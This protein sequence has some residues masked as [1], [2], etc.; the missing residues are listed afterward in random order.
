[1]N[2]LRVAFAPYWQSIQHALFPQLERVLG[3]LTEKQQQLVQTLEVIRIEQ[4]IPPR[5]RV[6]GR[7]PKDRAAMARAFVAKAVYDMPTTR[8]LRDRLDTDVVLRRICGWER[9]FEVPSE[10]V[11]SRAFAEFSDT[12]RQRGYVEPDVHVIARE[13]ADVRTILVEVKCGAE[14]GDN[15]LLQQWATIQLSAE[16]SNPVLEGDELRRGAVHVLLGYVRPR[17]RPDIDAQEA[18]ASA[19]GI[20]WEDRLI[21]ITWG[22]FALQLQTLPGIAERLRADV[23]S[24]LG[25]C[26][27]RCPRRA[28]R[29]YRAC[30]SHCGV[31]GHSLPPELQGR[32]ITPSPRDRGLAM[33]ISQRACSDMKEPE[34][35][36]SIDESRT[37]WQSVDNIVGMER[38]L[39]AFWA[40]LQDELDG[41]G[42]DNLAFVEGERHS[43]TSGAD[44]YWV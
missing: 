31:Q 42:G 25:G 37:V 39:G 24:F 22:Q 2:R 17:H 21:T 3:P 15:Q 20:A 16:V 43:S 28:L 1:M 33:D 44:D 27:W 6:P 30:G 18:R 36:E 13:G 8:G 23:L 11:F 12:T 38:S 19:A 34:L 32:S 14:L 35:A 40:A 10:S 41:I 29:G 9:K 4:M 5:F 26:A 7:P